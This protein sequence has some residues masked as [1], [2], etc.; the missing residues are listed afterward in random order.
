MSKNI[1]K[2]IGA[3]GLV[4]IWAIAALLIDDEII[5]PSIYRVGQRIAFMAKETMLVNPILT[6]TYRVL[7]GIFYSLISASLLAYISYKFS[8]EDYL[9][10]LLSFMRAIPAISMVLIVLFFTNKNVLSMIVIFFVCFPIIYENVLNGLKSIPKEKIE[11]AEIF[12]LKS[13]KIFEY[14]ELPAIIKSILFALTIAFGLAF[15]AGATA[16]VIAGAAGGLGDLL[17]MAKLSFEMAD[18][19]AVTFIIIILSFA[20]ETL[21]KYLYKIFGEKY[22]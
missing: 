18:L 9:S 10:P 19:L 4:S 8:L 22:A 20:F 6:T 16:E 21:A 15:K 3:A 17:Y 14:I 1:K 12:D 13:S 7:L 2:I 5:L 11:L